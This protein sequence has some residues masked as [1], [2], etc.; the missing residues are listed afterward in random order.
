M[1][2]I[3][4]LGSFRGQFGDH[5]EVR[6]ISGAIQIPSCSPA[7][8]SGCRWHNKHKHL[9]TLVITGMPGMTTN[10]WDEMDVWDG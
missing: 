3:S 9:G 8:V 10:D 4:G 5:F 2:I 6:I 7:V 1:G